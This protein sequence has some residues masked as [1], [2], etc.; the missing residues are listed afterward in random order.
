[1]PFYGNN[2][3][4]LFQNI[5]T[6][7]ANFKTQSFKNYSEEFINFLTNLLHKSS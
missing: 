7:E 5:L 3:E 4:N 2:T 1:M 6:K